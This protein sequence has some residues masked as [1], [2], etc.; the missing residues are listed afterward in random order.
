MQTRTNGYW[1]YVVEELNSGWYSVD[2]IHARTELG[3]WRKAIA[4]N[5]SLRGKR[6]SALIRKYSA[7]ASFSKSGR[8]VHAMHA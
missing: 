2:S 8:W 3:A 6:A 1:N 4:L 7:V 5:P